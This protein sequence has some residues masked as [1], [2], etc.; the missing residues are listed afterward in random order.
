MIGHLPEKYNDN[1]SNEILDEVTQSLT[2]SYNKIAI[3]SPKMQ[4]VLKTPEADRKKIAQLTSLERSEITTLETC[5]QAFDSGFGGAIITVSGNTTSESAL[6]FDKSV[7]RMIGLEESIRAKV[8]K[9]SKINP[10]TKMIDT[11]AEIPN[12]GKTAGAEV[13]QWN[14]STGQKIVNMMISQIRSN[15]QI[16]SEFKKAIEAG[17]R[18]SRGKC[19]EVASTLI[20]TNF[21]FGMF[22][23][24]NYAKGSE[25][26]QM[27]KVNLAG[28]EVS[29]AVFVA[30]VEEIF[31]KKSVDSIIAAALASAAE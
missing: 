23:G 3:L 5:A 20:H 31:K 6:A 24:F 10:D 28:K 15:V 7:T 27:E 16:I 30:K 1:M 17:S 19:A 12:W 4:E 18:E 13:I 29:P 22:A 11:R 8:L 21:L 25:I 26:S 2:E 14:K 9:I